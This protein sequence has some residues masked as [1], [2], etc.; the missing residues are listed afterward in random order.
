MPKGDANVH[1]VNITDHDSSAHPGHDEIHAY[2]Q[3]CV[4]RD[5]RRV[6]ECNDR[7]GSR[8]PYVLVHDRSYIF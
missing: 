4:S 6:F 8:F 2:R 3:E 7:S 1:T 5:S